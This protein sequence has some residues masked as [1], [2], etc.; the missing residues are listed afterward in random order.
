MKPTRAWLSGGTLRARVTFS[1]N[2]KHAPAM[3]TILIITAFACLIAGIR[4]SQGQP[5]RN[6]K[7]FRGVVEVLDRKAPVTL[8]AAINLSRA[9]RR[10]N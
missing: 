7:R 1:E 4:L 2:Q 9:I 3:S 6:R 8:A 5:P 10:M